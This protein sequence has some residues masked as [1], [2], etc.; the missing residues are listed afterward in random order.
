MFNYTD[1]PAFLLILV[2]VVFILL[3]ILLYLVREKNRRI[4]YYRTGD[5]IWVRGKHLK[6]ER[7]TLSKWD[8]F[9]F[10]YL[11]DASDEI[12]YKQWIFLVRNESD[13]KR[14]NQCN[15]E[16]CKN[17]CIKIIFA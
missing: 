12:K 9:T 16:R 6:P 17:P 10:C 8:D 14:K 11:P 13:I 1:F 3:I 5:V 7:A 2:E 4:K 15:W